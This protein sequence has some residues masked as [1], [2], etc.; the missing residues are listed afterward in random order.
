MPLLEVSD[1]GRNTQR[2]LHAMDIASS[3]P[4]LI[5]DSGGDGPH[6]K[7][8]QANNAFLI[9]SMTKPSLQAYCRQ[10]GIRPD[11]LFGISYGDGDEKNHEQEMG[12]NFR[13]L[14]PVIADMAGVS[15]T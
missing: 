8:G 10:N 13:D 14:I 15:L 2:A 1:K 4:V 9:G 6:F 5:G 12:V 11:L 3:R 7:W